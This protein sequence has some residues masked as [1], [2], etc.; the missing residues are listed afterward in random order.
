MAADTEAHVDVVVV[1]AGP[2]GSSAAMAAL[3]GGVSV[4]IIDKAAFPRAKLC[5]GLITGRCAQ[6]LRD[7]FGTQIETDLLVRRG[8]STV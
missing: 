8:E 1:G 6:H 3:K 2:S 5:G 7:I 4:A